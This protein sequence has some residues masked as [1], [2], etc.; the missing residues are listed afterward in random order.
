MT[1][2]RPA[3]YYLF[4]ILLI[5]EVTLRVVDFAKRINGFVSLSTHDQ[6]TLLKGACLEIMFLCICWQE[7][8]IFPRHLLRLVP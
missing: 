7:E 8:H 4:S 1:S 3:N 6:V 5:M 2:Q